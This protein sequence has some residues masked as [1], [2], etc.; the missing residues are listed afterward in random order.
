MSE[1]NYI[2]GWLCQDRGHSAFTRFVPTCVPVLELNGRWEPVK[3]ACWLPDQFTEEH[4]IDFV[5][6][7]PGEAVYIWLD[8]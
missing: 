8:A 1:R 4:D 2:E 7:K 3:G 5:M 6:P